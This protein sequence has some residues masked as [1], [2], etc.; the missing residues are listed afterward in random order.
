MRVTCTRYRV[1]DIAVYAGDEPTQDFPSQPPFIGIE[2]VSPE[3]RFYY[4]LEK[5]REYRN[6]GVQHIWLVDPWRRS[7]HVY[8]PTGLREVSVFQIPEYSVEITPAQI[9]R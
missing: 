2:I 9:F 4:L 6:W 5:F 8:D 3:D 7:I 1:A